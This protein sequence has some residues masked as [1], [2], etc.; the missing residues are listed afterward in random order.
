MSTF[1][2]YLGP[3]GRRWPHLALGQIK[4]DYTLHRSGKLKRQDRQTDTRTLSSLIGFRY[5]RAT[6][7]ATFVAG[8][9]D[10]NELVAPPGPVAVVDDVGR[11]GD[12]RSV[13]SVEL[14]RLVRGTVDRSVGGA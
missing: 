14:A 5:M 12:V 3:K 7:Q 11:V 1:I 9:H 13:V 10:F 2:L 4:V 8:L 6:V